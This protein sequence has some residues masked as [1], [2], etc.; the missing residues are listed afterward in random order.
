VELRDGL[1]FTFRTPAALLIVIMMSAVGTFGINFTVMLPLISEFVLDRGSAGLGFMTSA[2][3]LGALVSALLLASRTEV[4]R[5]TLFAGGFAF[6]ALLTLIAVSQMFVATLLLLVML[7][8]AHTT[9]AS[10]ANTSLQLTAPDHLRG[11]VMSLYMLLIA[12]S[13]PIGG[14]LTG[15]MAEHLGVSTAI[16]INASICLAGVAA[17]LVYY[18]GHRDEIGRTAG[19]GSNVAA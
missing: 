9:F 7:G 11:R 16:A 3:G 19:L 18:A 14:F 17:G 4:T 5:R 15:L 10:T 6:G 1:A 12:G 2:V 13:T 8:V